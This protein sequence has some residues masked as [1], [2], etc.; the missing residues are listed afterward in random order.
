MGVTSLTKNSC[1]LPEQC[2]LS[3]LKA[4]TTR[5]FSHGKPTQKITGP[6]MPQSH[7]PMSVPAYGELWSVSVGS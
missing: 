3:G 7:S 1:A 6:I 5:A 4:S 2:V